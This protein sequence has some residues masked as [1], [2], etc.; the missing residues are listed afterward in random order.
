MKLSTGEA[1]KDT[2]KS[3]KLTNSINSDGST[4]MEDSTSSD[5]SQYKSD[6]EYNERVAKGFS[7]MISRLEEALSDPDPPNNYV[8]ALAKLT[9]ADGEEVIE[10]RSILKRRPLKERFPKSVYG[11]NL[12]GT[13]LNGNDNGRNGI[14]SVILERNQSYKEFKRGIVDPQKLIQIMTKM[15]TSSKSMDG[16]QNGMALTESNNSKENGISGS[17]RGYSTMARPSLLR[18]YNTTTATLGGYGLSGLPG[19]GM[20]KKCQYRIY[21]TNKLN[22]SRVDGKAISGSMAAKRQIQTNVMEEVVD[23][24]EASSMMNKNNQKSNNEN[25]NDFENDSDKTIRYPAKLILDIGDIVEIR[26][27]Q[28]SSALSSLSSN[29]RVGVVIKKLAGRFPFLIATKDGSIYGIRA[30]DVGFRAQKYALR[31]SSLK[32]AGFEDPK[33]ARRIR[34]WAESNNIVKSASV[35]DTGLKETLQGMLEDIGAMS[36]EHKFLRVVTRLIEDFSKNS[37]QLK[38]GALKSLGGYWE[39]RMQEAETSGGAGKEVRVTTRELAKQI[40]GTQAPSPLQVF[41]IYSYFVDN[42]LY[43]IPDHSWLCISGGFTLRPRD[44]VEKL[45]TVLEWTRNNSPQLVS[46]RDKAR[47]LVAFSKNKRGEKV[48]K[49]LLTPDSCV[50]GPPLPSS[51]L[52]PL[53]TEKEVR[54]AKFNE[55]DRMIIWLLQ[56]YIYHHGSGYKYFRNPYDIIVPSVI[57]PLRVYGDVEVQSVAEFLIDIGVWPRWQNLAIYDR[58]IPI[59]GLGL[60]PTIDQEVELCERSVEKVSRRSLCDNEVKASP[61]IKEDVDFKNPGLG[62]DEFYPRDVVE[63]LRRDFGDTPVY[64]IDD[65]DTT[66]VDDGIS[67]EEVK[68]SDGSVSDWVHVHVA[69]PTRYIHPGHRLSLFARKRLE[70]L[71]P[72]ERTYHMLPTKFATS[73]VGLNAEIMSNENLPIYAMTFSALVN[74]KGD[75]EDYKVTP[76]ILRNVQALSYNDVNKY[77]NY[78][79]AST[80]HDPAKLVIEDGAS[81][82]AITL[83]KLQL[84]SQRHLEKRVSNGSFFHDLPAYDV[85]ISEKSLPRFPSLPS[86]P[87]RML[88]PT[89]KFDSELPE[90]TITRSLAMLSPSNKLV[91]EMMLIAGRV[92]ARFAYDRKI[93]LPFR[94]QQAPDLDLHDMSGSVLPSSIPGITSE[95]ARNAHSLFEAVRK[96]INPK[97]GEVKTTYYD[98]IRYMMNP[99][100]LSASPG[101][102][103][104]LGVNDPFGYTRVTSP[105][106]RYLDMFSHWQIKS[107]LL[108]K[109]FI[110]RSELEYQIPF[111]FKLEVA[112][113]QIGYQSKQIWALLKAQQIF[114]SDPSRVFDAY[115]VTRDLSRSFIIVVVKDFGFFSMLPHK[116]PGDV[117]KL[118]V[119]GTPVKIRF[120]LL[121]PHS[122]MAKADWAE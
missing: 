118:P 76:S 81:Q 13:L 89:N 34:E 98:E 102:H 23:D 97:T 113:K 59:E 10:N 48:E 53:L 88:V 8:D 100:I 45:K 112:Q 44:E 83:R 18:S 28:N 95:E 78:D 36:D 52:M 86:S 14:S 108:S 104:A 47:Q 58:R 38:W 17:S 32:M 25:D 80:T 90:I 74:S 96:Q 101:Q 4:T 122:N 5:I 62:I 15:K 20:Y 60:D 68:N 33:E 19:K 30:D 116:Y 3:E 67:L 61:V 43:F 50:D 49:I 72:P 21:S 85:K 29:M 35:K 91:S 6:S 51:A 7:E 111:M 79:I 12:K 42:V 77:M 114:K 105:I 115:V 26:D 41:A 119:A 92:A 103:Y 64:T 110:K 40:F 22:Q 82:E 16:G 71:Y 73:I 65:T 99:A 121:Q 94:T 2:G 84:I 106:R 1:N 75:I 63:S 27:S 117:D 39:M 66:D 24:M 56:Q 11:R 69:D 93:T 9:T 55:T 37:E 46:F 87:S 107:A 31:N 70:T 120:N 57:K 54:D 109:T